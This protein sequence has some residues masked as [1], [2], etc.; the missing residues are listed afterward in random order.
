MYL[1]YTHSFIS[2]CE[3]NWPTC[4]LSKTL[5]IIYSTGTG[6]EVHDGLGTR[7]QVP[8]GTCKNMNIEKMYKVPDATCMC[9]VN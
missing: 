2:P 3:P 9:N 4:H 8:A 5:I 6:V 1:Y 7:I